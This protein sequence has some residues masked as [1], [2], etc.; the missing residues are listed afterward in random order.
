MVSIETGKFGCVTY[1]LS[2]ASG[3]FFLK[4]TNISQPVREAQVHTYD[5]LGSH[6]RLLDRIQIFI[7]GQGIVLLIAR[8]TDAPISTCS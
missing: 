3:Y 1:V 7:L 8:L 2:L 5:L 6:L 4:E